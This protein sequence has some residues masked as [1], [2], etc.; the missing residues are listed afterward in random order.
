[1]SADSGGVAAS[2]H[3]SGPADFGVSKGVNKEISLE[4]SVPNNRQKR[5]SLKLT[6]AAVM[7]RVMA[8]LLFFVL[9]PLVGMAQS[10]KESWGN[11]KQLR[12]GQKIEVVDTSMK[13]FHGPF[14]AVSEE[15]VTLK[16]GK[17]QES[18]ERAKVAR[19]SVRDTSHRKRNML[20]GTAV[21]AG[22]GL[23][24]AIPVGILCSNEG[25]CGNGGGGTGAALAVV[26]LGAAGAGVGAIP[27]SRTVYR[28]KK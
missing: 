28:G 13:S 20:I 21:G 11:L 19:V 22:A 27:G 7:R 18:V 8:V 25:N 6:F 9:I 15:A 5:G 10:A 17:S 2:H 12:P 16:V 1:V 26:G 14:V 3:H 4:S 23:A 24:I